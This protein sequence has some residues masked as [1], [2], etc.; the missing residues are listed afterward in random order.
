MARSELDNFNIDV[1]KLK[2]GDHDY[3]FQIGN[4][5]F[6]AF[7]ESLIDKGNGEVK[8]TLEK[9]ETFIKLNTHIEVTVELS[10]DRSLDLFDHPINTDNEIILKFG[11]EEEEI[12]EE[13]MIIPRDRQRIN[14]AQFIYEFIM[15]SIPMKK[16]HP[17]YNEDEESDEIIYTSE[18]MPDTDEDQN[19]DIDPRW[20]KLKKLK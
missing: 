4:K 12:S 14:L 2:S 13:I 10:C 19:E 15:I 6:D 1:F 11:D 8:V 3:Q 7:P 5:F 17:R 9:T 20:Q 16:L 18:T